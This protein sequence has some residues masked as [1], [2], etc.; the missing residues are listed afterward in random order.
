M[1]VGRKTQLTDTRNKKWAITTDPTAI[2]RIVGNIMYNFMPV[3]L[4][5]GHTQQKYNLLKL[6]Q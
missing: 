5:N 6:T 1:W 2:K 4:T 3:N